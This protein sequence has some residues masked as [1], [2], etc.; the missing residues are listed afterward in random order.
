MY[1]CLLILFAPTYDTHIF[2]SGKLFKVKRRNAEVGILPSPFHIAFAI[3]IS[4]I[5][6]LYMNKP[7][8][9]LGL[10]SYYS[11]SP[12]VLCSLMFNLFSSNTYRISHQHL[13]INTSRIICFCMFLLLLFLLCLVAC[14]CCLLL[15]LSP[16]PYG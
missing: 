13:N 5:T 4:F 14:C 3:R 10:L 11:G 8:L 9:L 15:L 6:V 2:L 12:F 1:L 16:C 7:E